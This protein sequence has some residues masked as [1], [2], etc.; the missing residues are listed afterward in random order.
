MGTGN[1]SVQVAQDRH[2]DQRQRRDHHHHAQQERAGVVR[3]GHAV[4]VGSGIAHIHLTIHH[5]NNLLYRRNR[6][7]LYV[8]SGEG[9]LL[10][11]ASRL[12]AV[13]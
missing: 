2:G 13:S 4:R 10:C 9:R 7:G 11:G 8:I 12:L 1:G 3:G 5:G 6:A